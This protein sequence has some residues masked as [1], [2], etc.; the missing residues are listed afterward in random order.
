[1]MLK[2]TFM[3]AHTP[4]PWRDLRQGPVDPL[5][6][7]FS[8]STRYSSSGPLRPEYR[9]APL[10]PG[11]STTHHHET[12]GSGWGSCVTPDEAGAF[13]H[14]DVA[15]AL[16]PG[17]EG[18]R[19]DVVGGGR[20]GQSQEPSPKA[21]SREVR[22]DHQPADLPRGALLAGSDRSDQ[23]SL[24]ADAPCRPLVD[25][26]ADVVERFVE[27]ADVERLVG[28]GLVHPAAALQHQ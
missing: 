26:P 3:G 16:G 12:D 5:P 19:L 13:V 14:G 23:A 8:P 10:R 24:N 25:P 20:F 9:A 27:S 17:E 4:W 1:M 22:G 18:D 15:R 21:A 2:G 6:A 7:P 11:A 28:D